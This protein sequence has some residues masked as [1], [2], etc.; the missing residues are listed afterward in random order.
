MQGRK[1]EIGGEWSGRD[2]RRGGRGGGVARRMC[3]RPSHSE[4][5]GS[6]GSGRS[7]LG[8]SG[9][10]WTGG[11]GRREG[12]REGGREEVTKRG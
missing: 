4:S 12:G 7:P 6:R 5:Q 8:G 9:T 11:K 1:E 3:L 10:V 2:A